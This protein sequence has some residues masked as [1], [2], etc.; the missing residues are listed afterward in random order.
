MAQIFSSYTK[1]YCVWVWRA[2]AL[3][4]VLIANLLAK[5]ADAFREKRMNSTELCH[6]STNQSVIHF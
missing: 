1:N 3:A 5:Q 6:L 2:R 4:E